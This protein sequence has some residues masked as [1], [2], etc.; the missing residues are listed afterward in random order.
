MNQELRA[1]LLR[2][3]EPFPKHKIQHLDTGKGF[4]LAYVSHANVTERLL[5]IDPEWTWEPVAFNSNGLP[6]FDANGG[7]WIKLTVLGV[8]RYGYGEPQGRDEH[9]KVKGAIG[10]AIRV[11]AMR[12]GV[13]L[14]LWQKEEPANVFDKIADK[15]IR[16]TPEPDPWAAPA[17]A[18]SNGA[19]PAS[20]KQI[21]LVWLK[22]KEADLHKKSEQV[23]AV[24]KLLNRELL[25]LEELHSADVDVIVR[26]G[27]DGLK[28]AYWGSMGLELVENTPPTD[29]PWA[30]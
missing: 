25:S 29:D 9:D 28:K 5:E 21:K 7:L 27:I 3:R 30:V 8:S 1:E 26:A 16:E 6:A 14:E 15:A 19:K 22:C 11:A 23:A 24:G 13:G 17:R 10:N 4:S 12:F 18:G 2:L 20:E